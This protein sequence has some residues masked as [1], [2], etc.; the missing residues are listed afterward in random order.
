MRYLVCGL[1]LAVALFVPQFAGAQTTL[2]SAPIAANPADIAFDQNSGSIFV[3]DSVGSGFCEVFDQTATLIGGFV[4]PFSD[5]ETV[6]G[7]AVEPTGN[8]L[9]MIESNSLARIDRTDAAGIPLG[10]VGVLPAV[11]ASDVLGIDLDQT[12][13]VLHVGGFTFTASLPM[14][15]LIAGT[16]N[17]AALCF[18]PSPPRTSICWRGGTEV[19]TIGFDQVNG[20]FN[21]LERHDLAICSAPVLTPLAQMFIFG[22]DTIDSN[23]TTNATRIAVADITTAPATI[24]IV[25][26]TT[27]QTF[28][29]GDLDGDQMVTDADFGMLIDFLN[30]VT[31]TLPCADAADLDDDGAIIDADAVVLLNAIAGVAAPPAP[32]PACGVDPTPGDTLGC[33]TSSCP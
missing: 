32:F 5:F 6:R 22:I 15:S 18:A 24:N 28:V 14:S 27:A 20:T 17:G 3:P 23:P 11:T 13:Q 29:R 30:G 1:M 2:F 10:T 31:T 16:T 19:L 9:W 8:L 26:L 25:E 21:Q 4:M 33:N 7:I 12:G